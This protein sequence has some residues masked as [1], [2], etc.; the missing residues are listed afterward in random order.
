L[1]L[2][3]ND[4]ATIVWRALSTGKPMSEAIAALA[5]TSVEAERFAESDAWET[6]ASLL[7]LGVLRPR[8]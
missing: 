3:L 8:A 2:D 1:R 4:A 5:R 7:H 6:L